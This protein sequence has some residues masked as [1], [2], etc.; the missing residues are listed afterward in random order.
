MN[1]PGWRRQRVPSPVPALGLLLAIAFAPAAHALPFAINDDLRGVWNNRFVVA[2]AVRARDPDRQLVGANNAAEYPG[3]KAAVSAADDGNLNFR[4]GDALATTLT[5]IT[6]LELRYQRRYGVYVRGRA[7]YDQVGEKEKVPH[8]SIANAYVPD[9]RLDDSDYY[10]YNKFSGAELLDSYLYGNWDLGVSRFTGRFG[11]QAIN[12][13]ESLLHTGINAFNPLNYSLLGRPAISQDEALVPV[14][15]LY[16]NLITRNGVSLEAFYNLDWNESRIPPCGTLGQGADNL[17]D[18]ACFASTTSLPLPDREQYNFSTPMGNPLL[19]PT[20]REDKPGADGQFG[21]S[22]RYFVEPLDTEFGLY[23]VKYHTTI[24]TLDLSLCDNGPTGCS[25]LDGL[26]TEVTYAED[27]E[28][29]ALSAATGVRNVALTAELSYFRDLPAARNFPELVAGATRA[30]GIYS[31][32]MAEAGDGARFSGSYPVDRTQLLLGGVI[33]VASAVGLANANLAV[34]L[35]GQWAQDLPGTGR[36]RLG[37]SGNWGQ[38]IE[39]GGS[40]DATTAATEGGCKIDGFATDFSWGYRLLA[41][42]TLP[43]PARGLDLYPIISW[44]HD[45]EGYSVD[46]GQVE[47]RRAL[48]LRLRAIFQRTYFMEVGRVWFNS[49][50]NYDPLRDRDVY[51]IAVGVAF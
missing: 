18:P 1:R 22:A 42:V 44:N 28:A 48:A 41:Q 25:S 6:D 13:G 21:L 3:A 37:R 8:G 4:K 26:A 50:N 49:D 16:G 5:Y 9:T 27:L 23:Y 7:W 33:D 43:R 20:R 11:R 34:E 24:P 40:C 30:S 12:W 38:A 39:P 15:R 35:A 14:N 29:F 45:V 36:E 10:D 47:G 51:S 19:V 32:R 31:Q 17:F 2:T 46:G